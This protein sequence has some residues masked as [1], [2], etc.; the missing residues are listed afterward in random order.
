MGSI[1]F[2]KAP[3]KVSDHLQSSSDPFSCHCVTRLMTLALK[4]KGE[5]I[6]QLGGSRKETAAVF[7]VLAFYF[8]KV[9][10]PWCHNAAPP[11]SPPAEQLQSRAIKNTP[12][13]STQGY[14]PQTVRSQGSGWRE[15]MN[16]DGGECSS[17]GRMVRRGGGVR[18]QSQPSVIRSHPCEFCCSGKLIR[19]Q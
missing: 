7:Q 3:P 1:H 19:L 6:K 14:R 4:S 12:R 2:D 16:P 8:Q 17:G 5:P 13:A 10:H 15:A 11:H 9:V 18:L